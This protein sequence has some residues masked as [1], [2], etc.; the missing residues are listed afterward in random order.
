MCNYPDVAFS[1]FDI[2]LMFI[3]T[4]QVSIRLPS[5]LYVVRLGICLAHALTI[6]EGFIQRSAKT[7]IVCYIGDILSNSESV[8]SAF[9]EIN[10][11]LVHVTNQET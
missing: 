11:L 7:I 5:V 2:V 6:Q 9:A 4:L 10:S 1:C 8:V 3:H